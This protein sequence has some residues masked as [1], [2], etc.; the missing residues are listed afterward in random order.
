LPTINQSL[1]LFKALEAKDK[2]LPEKKTARIMLRSAG[3]NPDF[4]CA[5]VRQLTSAFAEL[6]GKC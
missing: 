6:P 1:S 5:E 3:D 2:G 4:G